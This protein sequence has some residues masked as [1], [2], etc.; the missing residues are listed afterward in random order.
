MHKVVGNLFYKLLETRLINHFKERMMEDKIK[1]FTDYWV[2]GDK[3]TGKL[4]EWC[5]DQWQKKE[6]WYPNMDHAYALNEAST[7][8]VDI[9]ACFN[10]EVPCPKCRT[11]LGSDI[12]KEMTMVNVTLNV[13]QMPQ[14]VQRRE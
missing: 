4:V 14:S 13:E 10:C 1:A 12:P 7:L 2:P 3:A 5:Q 11:E 9:P 8:P 6:S